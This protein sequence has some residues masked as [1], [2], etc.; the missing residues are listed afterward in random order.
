M[1]IRI[2]YSPRRRGVALKVSR[3]GIV[4]VLAPAGFPE[5]EVIRLLRMNS[6]VV[7]R[8]KKRA[9]KMQK[10]LPEL[11]QQSSML[12]LGKSYPLFTSMRLVQFDGER[13]MVPP[14]SDEERIGNL[15]QIYRKLAEKYIIPRAGELAEY[16]GIAIGTVKINKA[17]TRWGSCSARGDLNFSWHLAMYPMEL[18]ELVILHECA[19]FREMNHSPSFY[20]VLAEYLPDHRQRSKELDKWSR[21]LSLYPR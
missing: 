5:E 13:F 3:E 4:E 7:E 14:G 1:S 9:M 12:Y 16:F 8:L 15:E 21:K 2:V 18:I 6:S 10:K 20:R 17:V 11:S 19:H